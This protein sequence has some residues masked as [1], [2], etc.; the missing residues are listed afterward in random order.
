M[1]WTVEKATELGV[2][3]IRP[4]LTT[5]CVADKVNRDRLGLIAREA[6]EQCERLDVPEIADP[7][8]LHTALDLWAR[9]DPV[10]PLFLG[11]ER[12]AAPPL[13][14]H[15]PASLSR[16]RSRLAGRAGGRLRAGGA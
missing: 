9:Q 14:E 16:L 12:G 5:R 7:L 8:P 1:E 6:A 13:A 11:A 3:A 2:A 15:P 4:V 10:A